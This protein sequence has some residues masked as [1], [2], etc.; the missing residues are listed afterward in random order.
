MRLPSFGA[1]G[2]V[3][4]RF[5]LLSS[6]FPLIDEW[7]RGVI[8]LC[9]LCIFVQLDG[10]RWENDLFSHCSVFP[11]IPAMLTIWSMLSLFR[12]VVR[13]LRHEC[14]WASF[15]TQAICF[16]DIHYHCRVLPLENLSC[17]KHIQFRLCSLKPR[18]MFRDYSNSY[19]R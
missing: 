4:S 16:T 6:T 9:I 12:A 17:G 8:D 5:E 18:L 11:G 2:R 15:R 7:V 1:K 13:K 19:T 10:C 14:Q 3:F